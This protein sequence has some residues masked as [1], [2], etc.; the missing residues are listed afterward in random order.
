VQKNGSV[1]R[2]E[3]LRGWVG[4]K[5]QLT[6]T[7]EV[8]YRP[9]QKRWLD[10]GRRASKVLAAQPSPPGWEAELR[11]SVE[12]IFSHVAAAGVLF[13]RFLPK[14]G[15]KCA[16]ELYEE[17]GPQAGTEEAL[18]QRKVGTWQ[19]AH[20]YRPGF[21]WRSVIRLRFIALAHPDHPLHR[22]GARN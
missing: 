7:G 6:S 16:S 3:S 9:G 15:R 10:E 1:A 20:R 4:R 19:S 8:L 17:R 21:I 2:C 5:A 14:S 18:L 11:L 12:I 22:L 13:A